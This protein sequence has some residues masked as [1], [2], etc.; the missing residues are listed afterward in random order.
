MNA[1]VSSEPPTPSGW[2]D[3]YAAGVLFDAFAHGVDVSVQALTKYVG[4]HSDIL[5]GAV[6]GELPIAAGEVA[7]D[8]VPLNRLSI[9]ER[10]GLVVANIP[11]DRIA[12]GLAHAGNDGGNGRTYALGIVPDHRDAPDVA[13]VEH[14]R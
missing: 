6:S 11:E 12:Q 14:L 1:T 5:L 8:G 9:L 10:R 7:L 4:G 3:T 13:L 2:I